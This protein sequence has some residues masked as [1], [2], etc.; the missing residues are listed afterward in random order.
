MVVRYVL[1]AATLSLA[2]AFDV[3]LVIQHELNSILGRK[4][5]IEILTDSEFLFSM[6]S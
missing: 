2:H 1:G 5:N 3:S 4:L 6:S